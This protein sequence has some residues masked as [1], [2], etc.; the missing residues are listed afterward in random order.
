MPEKDSTFIV[1]NGKLEW[2]KKSLTPP[3]A[4]IIEIVKK[5]E[6]YQHNRYNSLISDKRKGKDQEK[7]TQEIEHK[8]LFDIDI[9]ETVNGQLVAESLKSH[10]AQKFQDT[11]VSV[12]LISKKLNKY[13]VSIKKEDVPSKLIKEQIEAAINK[14]IQGWKETQTM[15]VQGDA[16]TSPQPGKKTVPTEKS[17]QETTTGAVCGRLSQF[18]DQKTCSTDT[19]SPPAQLTALSAHI[20]PVQGDNV[21]TGVTKVDCFPTTKFP[22]L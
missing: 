17:T 8:Q 10:L 13:R 21:G 4:K 12:M 1:K 7:Q 20:Q 11:E 3:T 5:I 2:D 18:D 14:A 9:K 22:K 6:N 19:P 16:V 15:L